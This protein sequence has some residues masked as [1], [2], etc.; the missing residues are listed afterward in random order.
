MWSQ[1]PGAPKREQK[2]TRIEG[3]PGAGLWEALPP[4]RVWAPML[5]PAR[6]AHAPALPIWIDNTMLLTLPELLPV[7]T[8]SGPWYHSHLGGRLVTKLCPTC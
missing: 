1:K 6:D 8:V 7:S 5:T 4:D 2:E 3:R